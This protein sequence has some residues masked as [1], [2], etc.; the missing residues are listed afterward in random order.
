MPQK[1]FG[2]YDPLI[3]G[4]RPACSNEPLLSS[5]GAGW[6]DLLVE[7]YSV[8][9]FELNDGF[10]LNHCIA[11]QMGESASLE[12]KRQGRFRE[13]VLHPGDVSIVPAQL[14]HSTRCRGPLQFLS[15]SLEE[16]TVAL[17]A[18]D[19]MENKKIEL[20]L[21]YG[22]QDPL[23][24]EIAVALKAELEAGQP[25]GRLY[26]ETLAN[27]LAMHVVRKHAVNPVRFRSHR[28]GLPRHLLRRVL[29]FIHEKAL[30]PISLQELAAVAELSP[31]Y[32][33]RLFKQ[34]MGEPPYQYVLRC[35]VQRGAQMLLVPGA[36]IARVAVQTGFSD[37]SHFASHFKRFYGVS[38]AVYLRSQRK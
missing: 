11:I 2:V 29:D 22:V 33:T 8:S 30:D 10:V 14:P 17:A 32:F 19:L 34:S 5:A 27:T 4:I 3:G 7:H 23:I 25:S 28:G 6:G 1:K 35:R 26:G 9:S 24:R 16:T 13:A 15:L 21:K 12:C 18:S 31:F 20:S 38:P 36:T 37:Q